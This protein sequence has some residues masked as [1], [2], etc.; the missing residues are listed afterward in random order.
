MC[1]VMENFWNGF[2]EEMRETDP[3]KKQPPNWFF[4]PGVVIMA[5]CAAVALTR[6]LSL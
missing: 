5:L 6:L 1:G 3:A 2:R 4:W